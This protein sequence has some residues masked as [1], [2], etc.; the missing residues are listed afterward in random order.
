MLV[1]ILSKE[2]SED[3]CSY[4]TPEGKTLEIYGGRPLQI[5]KI[6]EVCYGHGMENDFVS[7]QSCIV[8]GLWA[9]S[10]K[11]TELLQ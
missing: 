11:L 3:L 5:W 4:R 7:C 2:W 9:E 10:Y 6:E 1:L 8:R